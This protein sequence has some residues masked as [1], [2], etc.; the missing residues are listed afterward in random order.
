MKLRYGLLAER[1]DTVDG[2][3]NIYGVF[4][5]LSAPSFPAQI[6][7]VAVLCIETG[8]GDETEHFVTLRVRDPD[9]DDRP[10]TGPHDVVWDRTALG[11]LATVRII[12]GITF[13]QPG[14]YSVD[15]YVDDTLLGSMSFLVLPEAEVVAPRYRETR[16]TKA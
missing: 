2:K 15:A 7:L 11:K 5:V 4:E 10:A 9:G 12:F 14:E 1:A 6:E 13:A 8:W 3:N 16:E